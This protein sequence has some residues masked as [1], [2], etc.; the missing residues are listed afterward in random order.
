[1]RLEKWY[2][3]C[4]VGN[5]VLV[6]YLA[7]L[8]L[9]PLCISYKG[10]LGKERS[11]KIRIGVSGFDMP[12]I[13]ER[14][15]QWPRNPTDEA[16]IWSNAQPHPIQLWKERNLAVTWDPLVLNGKVLR[17]GQGEIGQGYA[18]R[19]TLNL[20]P[21]SLGIRRLKWGRFCGSCHSLVWIEW[22]G[23]I[24]NRV[25]LLDGQPQTL[26]WAERTEIRTEQSRLV[27]EDPVEIV[28]ESLGEGALKALGAL[29]MFAASRFLLGI[30][31]KW[32]A[33]ASLEHQGAVVDRGS[34]VYEEVE[35]P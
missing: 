17:S 22:E 10:Q 15:M 3:D 31:T 33:A 7:R 24:P 29:R 27:I 2:A 20:P 25:A 18:E 5:E 30:E 1:M 6:L 23:K 4:G 11:S 14:G 21:W 13:D 28:S 32:R 8:H 16:L 34:V 12:S 19:L 35:W 26:L 9:G